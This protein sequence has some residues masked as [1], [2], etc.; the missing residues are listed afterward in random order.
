[1]SKPPAWITRLA[2]DYAPIIAEVSDERDTDDG[3]WFYLK[4]GLCF[5][6]DNHQVHEHDAFTAKQA[7]D[8]VIA[9]DCGECG[10][11]TR[12]SLEFLARRR[13]NPDGLLR[14]IEIYDDTNEVIG[15]FD[16]RAYLLHAKGGR[17]VIFVSPDEMLHLHIENGRI[18]PNF[19]DNGTTLRRLTMLEYQIASELLEAWREYTKHGK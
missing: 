12:A 14:H 19:S 13:K 7:L 3:V 2:K 18:D 10:T 15:Q 5:S 6:E 9:C 4:P 11:P 8:R 16:G 1:M 17:S